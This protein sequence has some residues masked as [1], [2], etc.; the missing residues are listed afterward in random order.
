MYFFT[1]SLLT[2]LQYVTGGVTA[3]PNSN[4]I[5]FDEDTHGAFQIGIG[6][7]KI[8]NGHGLMCHYFKI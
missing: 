6:I 7:P 3:R 2:F 5:M 1:T 4:R 8:Q